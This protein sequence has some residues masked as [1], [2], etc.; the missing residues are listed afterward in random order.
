MSD[1]LSWIE[2]SNSDSAYWS[3]EELPRKNNSKRVSSFIYEYDS[4][5][6]LINKF[7]AKIYKCEYDRSLSVHNRYG[8]YKKFY[9][10]DLQYN[11]T[12]FLNRIYEFITTEPKRKV[13][14]NGERQRKSC[15]SVTS[16]VSN[17][18]QV[19]RSEIVTTYSKRIS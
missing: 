7:G 9:Y 8:I 4:I 17:L 6:S 15:E 13:N 16:T 5:E 12:N 14:S 11:Q 19:A 3:C 18:V 10:E 2:P 1:S